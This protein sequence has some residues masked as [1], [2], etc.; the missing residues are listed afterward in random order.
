MAGRA[1][2]A[3]GSDALRA[4]ELEDIF[5]PTRAALRGS[6][7]DLFASPGSRAKSTGPKPALFQCCGT[8]DALYADNLRFR[9]HA[10]S[11]GLDLTYEEGPGAA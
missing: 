7:N 4:R 3:K 6:D 11:L 1:A 10:Q 8:E 9:E 5:G 2:H